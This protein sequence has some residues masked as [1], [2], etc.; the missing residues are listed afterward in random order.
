MSDSVLPL[1]G[2]REPAFN[3]IIENTQRSL[4]TEHS[5]PWLACDLTEALFLH[6]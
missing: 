3:D 5:L 1:G 2:H 6:L 4:V